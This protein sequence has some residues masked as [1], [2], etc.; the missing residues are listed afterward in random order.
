MTFKPTEGLRR[1]ESVLQDIMNAAI[2]CGMPPITNPEFRH[3]AKQIIAN[4]LDGFR[5]Q[6]VSTSE[7]EFLE[8]PNGNYDIAH[9]TRWERV[10][11]ET[12][13][14]AKVLADHEDL[15]AGVIEDTHGQDPSAKPEKRRGRGRPK[16]SAA[17]KKKRKA[18][19]QANAVEAE[20]AQ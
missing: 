7:P 6:A 5:P 17:E 9:G 20:A 19:K 8:A 13:E 15:I 2:A 3:G 16:L 10:E 14:H 1:A 18:A 4:A 12:P 11:P